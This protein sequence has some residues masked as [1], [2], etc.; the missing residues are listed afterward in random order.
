MI[1]KIINK[2]TSNIRNYINNLSLIIIL[3]KIQGKSIIECYYKMKICHRLRES[4][5]G[6]LS[7]IYT[8][9]LRPF[10]FVNNI[11]KINEIGD[12]YFRYCITSKVKKINSIKD[13]MTWNEIMNVN[14]DDCKDKFDFISFRHIYKKKEKNI[15]INL[16]ACQSMLQ[17]YGC[18]ISNEKI[19]NICNAINKKEIIIDAYDYILKISDYNDIN[20]YYVKYILTYIIN[21]R[22]IKKKIIMEYLYGSTPSEIAKKIIKEER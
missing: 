19:L 15:M 17:I 12:K 9:F 8:K 20:D 18:I 3:I 10:T 2:D 1:K 7:Y 4:T 16:D 5:D 22:S 11:E 14:I 6:S 21:K 13:T